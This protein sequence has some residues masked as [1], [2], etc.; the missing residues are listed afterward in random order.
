[1]ENRLR[2]ELDLANHQLISMINTLL[3][4]KVQ[5]AADWGGVGKS[6]QIGTKIKMCIVII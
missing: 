1:M 2:E 4:H 6:N 3:Y 5:T